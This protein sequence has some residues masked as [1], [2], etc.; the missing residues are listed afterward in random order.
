MLTIRSGGQT[1]V[2][3]AALDA[4]IEARLPV[5]GWCPAGR[6]AEDGR[7]PDRYPLAETPRA[8]YEERTR[9]NVRDADATLILRR[10]PLAGGTALTAGHARELR[11]PLLVAD[12]SD[13]LAPKAIRAWLARQRVGDLNVAGPRESEDAGIYQVALRCLRSA[14]QDSGTSEPGPLQGL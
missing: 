10:T 2:D 1:G 5:A 12:P 9:L 11:R 8:D 4:A 14:F 6:R 7:I 13:Q 3:R